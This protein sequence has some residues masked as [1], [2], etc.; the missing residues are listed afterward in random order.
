[1]RHHA[2][3]HRHCAGT[4]QWL[5]DHCPVDQQPAKQTAGTARSWSWCGEAADGEPALWC[6]Q[7]RY[8]R[9]FDRPR[10]ADASRA[11]SRGGTESVSE[12]GRS[13]TQMARHFGHHRYHCLRIFLRTST[14]EQRH[15]GHG[16][17]TN[18]GVS[19]RV[20]LGPNERPA[21][22]GGDNQAGRA[23][24]TWRGA[25]TCPLASARPLHGDS[26]EH[27]ECQRPVAQR[28]ART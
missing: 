14:G 24:D 11:R 26:V 28:A 5:R 13:I 3:A 4:V 7:C 16:T 12:G 8:E 9:R 17:T 10:A 15:S 23:T 1:M 27:L 22:L 25:E 20:F 2:D 6:G 21:W 19:I 18:S